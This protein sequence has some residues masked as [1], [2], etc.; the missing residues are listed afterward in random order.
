M[1]KKVID[2]LIHFFR[3]VPKKVI[4]V[5]IYFFRKVPKKVIDMKK[6]QTVFE[7]DFFK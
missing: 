1:P 5:L 7:I 4:D 3:K 2:V 6:V